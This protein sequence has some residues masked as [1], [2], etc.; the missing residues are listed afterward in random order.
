M[1]GPVAQPH[2]LK[3]GLGALERIAMP[4]QFQ[5][6]G[7]VLESGHRRD[8]V[9]AL[10]HHAHVIAAEP[11]ER[12]LIHGAQVLTQRVDLAAGGALQPAHQHQQRRFARSGRADQAD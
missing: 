6:S 7:H 4:R 1:P 12:V 3:L 8:Q 2:G 5:R 11:R 10:E 9:K